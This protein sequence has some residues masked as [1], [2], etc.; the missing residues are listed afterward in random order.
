M[1]AQLKRMIRDYRLSAKGRVVQPAGA[2]R[3]GVQCYEQALRT[4]EKKQAA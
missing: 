1:I 2:I 3:R 4:Q